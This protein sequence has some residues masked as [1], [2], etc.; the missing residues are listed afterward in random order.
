MKRIVFSTQCNACR[1]LLNN[2]PGIPPSTRRTFSTSCP[3]ASS[4]R[5]GGTVIRRKEKGLEEEGDV[6]D[7]S[8]P[9]KMLPFRKALNPAQRTMY[10]SLSPEERKTFREEYKAIGEHLTSPRVMAGLSYDFDQAVFDTSRQLGKRKVR[11]ERMV[12]GIM[13]MGQ[14]DERGNGPDEDPFDDSDDMP[15]L[16]HE[17]L[18]EH[19]DIRHYARI[20][21]W[22]MPLLYSKLLWITKSS[23]LTSI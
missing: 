23:K 18:N 16:A 1:R 10:A 17:E 11:E 15:S 4:R 13:A 8:P 19:K 9:I 20:A 2:Q 5:A 14:D 22:E 3:R 6:V 21:A 7:T 12:S